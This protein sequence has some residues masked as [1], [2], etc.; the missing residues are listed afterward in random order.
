MK[1]ITALFLLI[2]ICET[3]IKNDEDDDNIPRE[4]STTERKLIKFGDSITKCFDDLGC[5]RVDDEWFDKKYR[6]V[7]FMPVDPESLR[8]EFL[9]IKRNNSK[10]NAVYYVVMTSNPSSIKNSG[11]DGK[12]STFMLIHDFTSN[13]FAGWIKHISKVLF[14]RL[15]TCNIVSVD[16]QHGA[17]PPYDQA[18][19]N[20][21][22]VALEIINF[23]K[24]LKQKFN[25]DVSRLHLIGHGVGAHIAGYVGTVFCRIKK[26]TGLDPSGP[27]FDKMSP[28]VTL[29]ASDAKY[30]EVLHT[31]GIGEHHQGSL[32]RFGHSDFYINDADLQPGCSQDEAL[33]NLLSVTR[34]S[35]EECQILPGCSHKMAYKYFIESL[36]AEACSFLGIR[37]SSYQDFINGKCTSCDKDRCRTFGMA[38][39]NSTENNTYASYYLQT[40]KKP[41]YC[42]YQ[43]RITLHLKA[44]KPTFT[45]YFKFILIDVNHR[46]TSS[47]VSEPRDFKG[48]SGNS[49]VF[50]AGS[51]EMGKIKSAKIGWHQKRNVFCIINCKESVNVEKVSISSINSHQKNVST[52]VL[53]PK[54]GITEIINGDYQEFYPCS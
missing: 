41:P 14:T 1:H 26:I 6:P 36:E 50:Y 8:T 51:P 17:E 13:G 39:F 48:G 33:T 22:T 10:P 38:T 20:A 11:F 30:V 44:T 29:D 45:G 19:A 49:L 53:C 40:S 28:T 23:I 43:Y 25:F 32:E 54:D 47:S 34:D 15:K 21:R 9:Y 5:I 7:N 3:K 18:I 42:L 2:L 31:D 12:S 46:V 52:S 35:L 24:V 4:P 27:R 37:C 16:W